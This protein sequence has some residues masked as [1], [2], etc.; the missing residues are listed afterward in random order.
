MCLCVELLAVANKMRCRKR[1]TCVQN[2]NSTVYI[3][4]TNV[5]FIIGNTTSE[6]LAVA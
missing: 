6:T 4:N 3:V 5:V 2:T 1:T